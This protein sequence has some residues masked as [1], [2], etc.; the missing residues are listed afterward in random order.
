MQ[1]FQTF[2]Y[3]IYLSSSKLLP[4]LIFPSEASKRRDEKFFYEYLHLKAKCRYS[5][6][7]NLPTS[8]FLQ[9]T[10]ILVNIAITSTNW[11]HW[12]IW[13]IHGAFGSIHF[14]Q[15]IRDWHFIHMTPAKNQFIICQQVLQN[16]CCKKRINSCLKVKSFFAKL[17]FGK[18][19]T[20]SKW[21]FLLMLIYMRFNDNFLTIEAKDKII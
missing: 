15:T 6:L 8:Q 2:L 1:S 16:F 7:I 5:L 10:F 11:F 20:E 17:S 9:F 13:A 12:L 3:E 14:V 21:I 4:W 18:L 19:Y